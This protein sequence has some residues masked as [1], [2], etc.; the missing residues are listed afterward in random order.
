MTTLL[1]GAAD[2]RALARARG[3][4]A[5]NL[6]DFRALEAHALR[7]ETDGDD[8]GAAAWA[9]IAA[10]AAARRHTGLLAAPALE[11]LLNR[12]GRAHVPGDAGA[13]PRPGSVLHVLTEAYP[14][15]GHTKVAVNWVERDARTPGVVL[16]DQR[17]PVPAHLREA[18][19]RRG[20]ALH[21]GVAGADLFARA[22]ALRA[23]AAE[24][25]IVVL[26]THMHDVLAAL[27]F[28]DPAHRPATV[29]FEHADGMLW[30]GSAAADVVACFRGVSAQIAS[31]RRGIAPERLRILPLPAPSR[32]VP[33]RQAA[34]AALGLPPDAPV[35]LSIANPYKLAPVVEPAFGDLCAR[36]LDAVPSAHLL[37][38]GPPAQAA[39]GHPRL[40]VPGPAADI[41]PHLAAAD[42]LLDSWPVTGGMTVLDAAMAGVPVLALDDGTGGMGPLRAAE[43][44]L[45]PGL[46]RA[47]HASGLAHAGASLLGAPDELAQRGRALRAAVDRSHGAGWGDHVEAIAEAALSLR[48]TAEVP[49]DVP[50]TPGDWDCVFHLV[51]SEAGHLPSVATCVAAGVPDLPAAARPTTVGELEAVVASVLAAGR[52]TARRALAAPAIDAAGI[53]QVVAQARTLVASGEIRSCTVVLPPERLDEGVALLEAALATGDD[54][55]IDVVVGTRADGLAG[56]GDVLLG[57]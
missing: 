22:R 31:T 33:S 8:L 10:D 51:R 55:D 34:R 20:G 26:H 36:M 29:L 37:V 57:V 38:V 17:T 30:I 14:V 54:I 6:R 56:E 1:S 18:V 4:I 45:E 7:L 44:A 39:P 49:A 41:A 13:R 9:R 40:V 15:G 23:L 43:P 24:H 50:D 12:L 21:E 42:L 19:A 46:V 2:R 53:G 3:E 27:A 48:G 5:M 52:P 11:R 32:T 25:E 35:L 16:T 28:A 47:A